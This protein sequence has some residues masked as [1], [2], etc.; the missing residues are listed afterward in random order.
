LFKGIRVPYRSPNDSFDLSDL[1]SKDPIEHFQYWFE[2][3]LKNK[4]SK[5]PNAVCIATCT[6]EGRPSNRMV[7][8]KDYSD[9]G[10]KFFTNYTSKKGQELEMNPYASMCFY[11]DQVSRQVRVEGKVHKISNEESYDYFNKRP[12]NSRISAY[13]SDQSKV[14]KDRKV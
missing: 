10:F 3:I 6:K 12:L 2:Y 13:I 5:E 14:I 9:K 11:W 8:L 4:L 1:K 7:L